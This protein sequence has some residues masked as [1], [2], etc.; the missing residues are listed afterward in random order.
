MRAGA[1]P[2]PAPVDL[3]ASVRILTIGF[4]ISTT[5]LPERI[6]GAA[7]DVQSVAGPEELPDGSDL[8]AF[9]TVI[10]E[11]GMV[12]RLAPFKGKGLVPFLVGIGETDDMT[13]RNRAW[14]PDLWLD[15]EGERLA[16]ELETAVASRRL[17]AARAEIARLRAALMFAR[18]TAH[19]LAQPLT[20][21]MARSQMLLSKTDSE[22]PHHR[23]LTI[24]S[25]E[26]E[27]LAESIEK[28]QSL[29]EMVS[30]PVHREEE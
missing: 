24:I 23:P 17:D 25:Q 4:E 22:H 26:A 12:S 16:H 21:V 2:Q 13:G 27:R 28:F 9:D 5:S 1:Q 3:D 18:D 19:D 20:T 6:A 14:A 10:V 15:G 11:G 30:L 7:V 8:A 29:K